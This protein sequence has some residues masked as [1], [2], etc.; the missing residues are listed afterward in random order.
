VKSRVLALRRNLSIGQ[1]RNGLNTHV[2]ADSAA[3]DM[4]KI[5]RIQL[6][7]DDGRKTPPDRKGR[8]RL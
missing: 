6:V 5:R 8:C 3:A 4:K 2:L 7:R 1:F